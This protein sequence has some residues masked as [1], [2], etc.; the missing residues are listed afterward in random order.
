MTQLLALA[1]DRDPVIV[2]G[3]VCVVLAIALLLHGSRRR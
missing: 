3:I 2:I 1:S